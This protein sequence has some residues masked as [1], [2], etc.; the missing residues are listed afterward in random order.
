MVRKQNWT[1]ES[2]VYR[3]VLDSLGDRCKKVKDARVPSKLT[4]DPKREWMMWRYK[5][6]SEAVCDLDTVIV[7]KEREY[8]L[9]LWL[10]SDTLAVTLVNSMP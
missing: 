2:G 3:R 5:S 7:H 4:E 9:P 8:D 6:A 1:K 10:L